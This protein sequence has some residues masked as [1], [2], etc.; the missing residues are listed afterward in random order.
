MCETGHRIKV[1][2][3]CDFRVTVGDLKKL[4][5]HVESFMRDDKTVVNLR[6]DRIGGII[7]FDGFS[8]TAPIYDIEV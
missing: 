3:I 7:K 6:H 4:W 8:S 1:V 2:D 5:R